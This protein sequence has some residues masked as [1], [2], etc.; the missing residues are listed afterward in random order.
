MSFQPPPSSVILH[1]FALDLLWL[2]YALLLWDLA[3]LYVNTIA[4]IFQFSYTLYFYTY[5]VEKHNVKRVLIVTAIF[6]CSVLFYV[7]YLAVDDETAMYHLG[8]TCMASS[9]V[10]FA[11]P[12]ASVAE[13]M[14]TQCTE[15]LA[16]SLCLTNFLVAIQ[17]FIY[18]LI[19]KN[20]FVKV[21]NMLGSALC[22]V[23]LFLFVIYPRSKSQ[24]RIEL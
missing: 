21:P 3:M 23:Q 6:L 8:L 13:V 18:G 14:R 7:K 12:L 17:W 2:K 9:V 5:T 22:L 15:C 11:S 1:L 4:A 10:S 24:T 16:F 20:N 19:I